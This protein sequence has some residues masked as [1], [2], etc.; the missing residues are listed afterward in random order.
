MKPFGALDAQ[1]RVQ[2]HEGLL[3][4]VW[5]ARRTTVLFIT[6]DVDEALVLSDRIHVMSA[7]PGR[8]VETIEVTSA[9]PR[10]VDEVDDAYVGNRN[11]ILR[12]LRHAD[13][14]PSHD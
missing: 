12:L 1:T 11:R 7:A 9:R 6:H 13:T 4:R 2:M 14:F 8:I 10:W 5:E 3:L